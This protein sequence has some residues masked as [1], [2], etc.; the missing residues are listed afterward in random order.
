MS[1]N[2]IN[3]FGLVIASVHNVRARLVMAVISYAFVS[4][5][6]LVLTD[7]GIDK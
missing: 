5:L 3:C 1:V 7:I 4:T 6:S 2:N